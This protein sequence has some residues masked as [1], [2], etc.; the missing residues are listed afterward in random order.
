MNNHWN[1]GAFDMKI[2]GTR[3]V[4]AGSAFGLAFLLTCSALLAC[5][6]SLTAQESTTQAAGDQDAS[7][8]G[9]SLFDGKT[10]DGWRGDPLVWSVQEGAITGQTTDEHPIKENT[11]LI[12]KGG[13]VGDFELKLK[14]RVFS[15]NS[16]VQYRSQDLGEY[17]VA[18][19]QADMDAE[20][21][22]VGILYDERGRGILASRGEK[23][24]IDAD[25][26]R[27]VVGKCSDPDE[28]LKEVE[29]KDWNEYTIRA[30]GNHLTQTL[31]GHV[32]ID[33][34]DDAKDAERS[35]ILALQVHAGS[36]MKVQFKDITLRKLSADK[37]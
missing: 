28:L 25:G 5:S 33:L 10:L 20:H 1:L 35:G 34:T 13:D 32:S 4:L 15:G 16:G 8:Q 12:W 29:S 24:A 14:F 9:V 26:N 2:T 36:P 11:F 18:G 27:T 17:R 19:Y 37:H 30:E 23:V 21:Q 6:A 3:C 7:A 31:N 22:Y